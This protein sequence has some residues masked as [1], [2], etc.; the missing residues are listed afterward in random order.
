LPKLWKSVNAPDSR[1]IYRMRGLI[2]GKM[3]K[4]PFNFALQRTPQ[5]AVGWYLVILLVAFL[6]GVVIAVLLGSFGM[7]RGSFQDIAMQAA[8]Y[9]MVVPVVVAGMLGW[10]R[11]PTA[12]NILLAV[13]GAA[14]GILVGWLGAGVPLAILTTRPARKNV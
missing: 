4:E 6:F 10:T 2:R 11:P 9:G 8:P 14:L 5:Q 3:F 1:A 7:L 12:P 13:G